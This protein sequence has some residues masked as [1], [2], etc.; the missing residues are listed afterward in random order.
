[1]GEPHLQTGIRL[2]TETLRAVDD[3]VLR[4][5]PRRLSPSP[6]MGVSPPHL[7]PDEVTGSQV[8]TSPALLTW[9]PTKGIGSEP[10]MLLQTEVLPNGQLDTGRPGHGR[11]YRG[12]EALGFPALSAS[13]R[14]HLHRRFRRKLSQ[15]Q[16]SAELQPDQEFSAAPGAVAHGR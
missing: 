14:V 2:G 12:S 3:P 8:G 11:D 4:A 13:R 7:C 15:L 5:V 6:L 1:M 9:P 10:R 16:T